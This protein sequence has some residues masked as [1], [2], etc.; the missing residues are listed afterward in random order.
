MSSVTILAPDQI[1][2]HERFEALNRRIHRAN[3]QALGGRYRILDA[4]FKIVEEGLWRFDYPDLDGHDSGIGNWLGTLHADGVDWAARSTFYRKWEYYQS[5]MGLQSMT[6]EGAIDF[7][8]N[9]EG[10]VRLL[11]DSGAL[12]VEKQGRGL[13]MKATTT[14]TDKIP[15]LQADPIAYLD[16]LAGMSTK[17]SNAHVLD[18]TGRGGVFVTSALKAHTEP[19]VKFNKTSVVLEVVHRYKDEDT[20]YT[21]RVQFEEGMPVKAKEGLIRRLKNTFEW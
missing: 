19:D 11:L 3:R 1:D 8:A 13:D 4:M 10:A 12:E 16:A 6:R 17:E 21:C 15:E 18:R 9:R 20:P 14:A 2:Q 5:L 7:V